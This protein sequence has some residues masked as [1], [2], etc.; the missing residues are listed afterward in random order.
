MRMRIAHM[1]VAHACE[2]ERESVVGFSYCD[3][4]THIMADYGSDALFS[5]AEEEPVRKDVASKRS[6]ST[7][8]LTPEN[9][10]SHPTSSLVDDVSPH[11]YDTEE[12]AEESDSSCDFSRTT[13]GKQPRDSSNASTP[14]RP[15]ATKRR[16]QVPESS[17]DESDERKAT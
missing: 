17:G 13:G 1:R 12:V 7:R 16:A 6:G 10:E 9:G 15:R 2:F 8:D 14:F 11:A 4:R 5:D 3:R